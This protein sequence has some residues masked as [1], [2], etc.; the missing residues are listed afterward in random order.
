[1][2]GITR[3]GLIN[4]KRAEKGVSMKSLSEQTGIKLRTLYNHITNP[5]QMTLGELRAI[6]NRLKF[7]DEELARF[8][9]TL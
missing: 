2:D 7:S 3:T 4:R 9:K 1:M 6:H 5:D 8:G